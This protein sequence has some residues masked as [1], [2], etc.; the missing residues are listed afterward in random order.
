LTLEEAIV[1]A[2]ANN[3]QIRVVSFDPAIS[4]EEMIREAAAFD[5]VLFGSYSY[6]RV[7]E[8]TTST[9]GGG[10]SDT[11]TLQAGIRQ[12]LITGGSWAASYSLS[13]VWDSSTFSGLAI[14]HEPKLLL[15]VTQPLLRDAWPEFN[16]ARLRIAR[17]NRQISEAVFR[18]QVERIVT[19]EQAGGRGGRV[20]LLGGVIGEYWNLWLTRE[21]LPILRSLLQS[22]QDTL[23]KVKARAE[24]DAGVAQIKQAE[25]AV[26][27]RQIQLNNAEKAFQGA[28]DSLARLLSDP[29]VN[30]LANVEIVPITPPVRAKVSLDVADQLR[31]ALAHSPLLEQARLAIA[32]AEITVAMAT[33]Q[34][35]PQLNLTGSVGYQGLGA[36]RHEGHEKLGTLDYLSYSIGISFEYPLG[37]RQRRADLRKADFERRKEI[38]VMQN[39]ADQIAGSVKERIREVHVLYREIQLWHAL[40]E[41]KTLEL[42]ALEDNEKIRGRLTPEFLSLKLATQGQLADA[43]RGELGATVEYN[44]ALVGLAGITGTIL[45]MHGVDVALLAAAGESEWPREPAAP[46]LIP[47]TTPPGKG[48]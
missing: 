4:R 37:N 31:T 3:P 16:L 28:Q 45:K 41:A 19:G 48:Q 22:A 47:V 44:G 20:F 46:K 2:L 26:H 18:Q 11:Q 10:Q 33:N 15:E 13:R 29:Q 6:D 9:F 21:E 35:L 38:A 17:V 34:T 25:A 12:D 32:R 27:D 7:D 14:R 5:Y 43:R 40:V 30:L 23:V 24:I 42:Q 36:T 1:R 39:V 8:R